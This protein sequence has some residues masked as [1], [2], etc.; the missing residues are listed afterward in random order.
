MKKVPGLEQWLL[1]REAISKAEDEKAA[2]SAKKK[3]RGGPPA[4]GAPPKARGAGQPVAPARLVTLR[5]NPEAP[6]PGWPIVLRS[7]GRSQEAPRRRARPAAL[8]L[9]RP[10][11]ESLREDVLILQAALLLG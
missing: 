10:R 7:W 8:L 11:E 2:A 5:E 9:A 1:E 6:Q 3:A 4:A